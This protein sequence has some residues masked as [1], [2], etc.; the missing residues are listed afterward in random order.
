MKDQLFFSHYYFCYLLCT[1]Q[2]QFD[3]R[4]EKKLGHH[5]ADLKYLPLGNIV[6]NDELLEVIYIYIYIYICYILTF[7]PAQKCYS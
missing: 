3:D 7:D 1:L 5:E 6:F 2:Y 4:D